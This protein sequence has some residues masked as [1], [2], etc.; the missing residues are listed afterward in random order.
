MYF[1]QITTP[2]LGCF[3]Y[4]IGCP[5][6]GEMVV[7]DP[8]RDVQDY[9]DISREEGM[10][11]VHV[12]DTHVHADHVSGAQELKSQTGCDI[13]VYETSPVGYDFTPLKEGQQLVVGNAK[14]EVLFTPG[15]TPDAL[16]LLVTDTTRGDEPWMLLTGDVLFVGDIGRPDLV[17]GAKLNEQV[18]NLWNSLYVKFA[19]FPDSLEVFPAHGAGSLC[20]RGMSSKPSSTLGFERRHNPMLGFDNFED[21]HLAMSQNFPARPKS[22]THII[23][24]N[25]SGAPLLERCPLDLAMNPYKFEEKMQDGAVVV[26]VRDAAA[27]AGYHIPGSLNIGFEPSLANWVGMTVEPDAD[28]LLVVDTRDDYER[29]RIELHRIGYDN[30]LGYLS[31]GIQAWVYSGRPVDSLAIDSAQVLQNIQEEGKKISLID[32]R[33]PV[34]WENG[35]IPGARHIPLVDILDGKFDLDEDTHH[36]LYCAAGY[37]ANIAASY[38]QKHGYWDVR[39]LAGGYIAWSRAGFKTEK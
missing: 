2:G 13:M 26:D 6:A 16:S 23:S 18:Q 29:M 17:G 34:E 27:Y 37:R 39:S 1:K 7:V 38:L 28:I 22:F 35:H 24:T 32:V 31:G 30:I 19:K 8:K 9:L 36:L 3:S 25:A 12:I 33:T 5:A 15:H 10:R 11:I 20:G 21:F 4:V 14:L